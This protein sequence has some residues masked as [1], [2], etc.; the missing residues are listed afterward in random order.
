M[1]KASTE[2]TRGGPSAALAFALVLAACGQSTTK[3]HDGG[4]TGDLFDWSDLGF[5][6][7][8]TYPDYGSPKEAGEA[9][10]EGGSGYDGGSCSG[11][12]AKCTST[13]S[14]SQVCTAANSGTCTKR[15]TLTGTSTTKSLLAA[16][17]EGYVD[18][19]N[20]GTTTLCYTLDTCGMTGSGTL[21]Q[22]DIK[23][24]VCNTAQK[25]DFKNSTYYDSAKSILGCTPIVGIER[26]LWNISTLGGGE[27]GITCMSYHD[28]G[29]MPWDLDRV[30]VDLCKNYPPK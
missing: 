17:V 26:P 11:P 10:G 12:S 21:A 1:R 5:Y 3:R 23:T 2:F 27:Y 15:L 16:L 20:K 19:W 22:S 14:S 7:G 25:T 28:Y 8:Y 4:A 29:S 30:D 18:C 6:E 13:C 24:W 9:G